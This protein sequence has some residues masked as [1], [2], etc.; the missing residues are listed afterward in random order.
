MPVVTNVSQA[1]RLCGSSASIASR[2]ASEI[3]S[4]ILSGWPSVTDSEV[5]RKVRSPMG[6]SVPKLPARF[7]DERLVGGGMRPVDEQAPQWSN[8]CHEPSREPRAAE[9]GQ[10]LE[11]RQALRNVEIRPV[12]G[13][14]G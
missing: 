8:P 14:V 6:R 12:G 4:A 11:R 9:G 7:D 2:T 3:W 1:T 13:R 5:K 10:A